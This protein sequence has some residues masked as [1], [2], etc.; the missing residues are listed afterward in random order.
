[1]TTR[2]SSIVSTP[3]AEWLQEF[4][5]LTPQEQRSSIA[6]AASLPETPG[7]EW[8]RSFLAASSPEQRGCSSTSARH[9]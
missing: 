4:L 3:G 5:G 7:R 2:G 9:T 6:I 1:M 8:L